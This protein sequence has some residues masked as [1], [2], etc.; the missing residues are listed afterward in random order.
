MIAEYVSRN[1]QTGTRSV[2]YSQSPYTFGQFGTLFRV[3]VPRLQLEVSVPQVHGEIWAS[4]LWE[5]RGV[6][7]KEP[8]ERLVTAA[9][10]LT[11]PRPSM[12][13]ARDAVLQA[14]EVSDP[15]GPLPCAIWKVFAKRGFGDSAAL[16][17]VQQ[18]L[19]NDTALSV[20]EAFDL[21]SACGGTAPQPVETI[22]FDGAET[23][24]NG[25][26]ASGLWRLTTRRASAGERAWWFGDETRGTYETG[27]RASGSLTSP[28]ISLQG[29]EKAIL[30]WDQYLAAEGVGNAYP[31]GEG[32]AAPYVNVDSGWLLIS[33]DGGATWHT[34]TTLAHNSSRSR[35]DPHRIDISRFAGS[36]ILIRFHFDTLDDFRNAQEGWY[37]DN[38]RV[39]R[40]SSSARRVVPTHRARTLAAK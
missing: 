37:I 40:L 31:L 27:S 5:L 20:Y 6:L 7:G 24:V 10:R 38:V 32:A 14:A 19:P 28:P 18:G 3:R 25:W 11:P 15:G 17:H 13:D 33:A 26:A 34:V 36:T 2:A 29:V 21:P 1:G 23:G 8:F 35:F 12:L 16:N 22:F 9:L 30:E 39:S 4:A